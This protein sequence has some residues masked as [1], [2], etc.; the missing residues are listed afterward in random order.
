M[1]MPLNTR[2]TRY[3]MSSTAREISFSSGIG[4]VILQAGNADIFI[5]YNLGDFDIDRFFTLTA[6]STIVLDQPVPSQNELLYV[7]SNSTTILEVWIT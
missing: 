1:G 6:G 4:K 2:M 3:T 5:A 7:K